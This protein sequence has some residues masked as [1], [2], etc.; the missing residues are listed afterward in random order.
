[1]SAKDLLIYFVLPWLS[2]MFFGV[3]LGMWIKEKIRHNGVVVMLGERKY[4]GIL[5]ES[6]RKD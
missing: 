4:P 3:F 5:N 6:L 2:G 1:M